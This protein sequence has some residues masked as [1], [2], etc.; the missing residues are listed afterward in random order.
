MTQQPSSQSD[1][2]PKPVRYF[3]PMHGERTRRHQ[4]VSKG[5][6]GGTIVSIYEV[7]HDGPRLN[8]EL[9]RQGYGGNLV[10]A[11]L[12]PEEARWLC[13]ACAEFVAA[14]ESED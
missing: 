7:D 5:C 6:R 8:V 2:A 10:S 11:D 4:F 13:D 3:G 1:D 12:T 9:M 14:W